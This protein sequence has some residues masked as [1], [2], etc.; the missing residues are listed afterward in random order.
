MRPFQVSESAKRIDHP[1]PVPASL[2]RF[3]LESEGN[4]P[5]YLTRLWL[6]EGVPYIFQAQ[7]MLYEQMR[8]WFGG[9]L[10][11]D[12]KEIIAIGSA[13][14]GYSLAPGEGYGREF[15]EQVSDLDLSVVSSE[16]LRKLHR[17][18]ECWERDYRAGRVEPKNHGERHYWPRNLEHIPRTLERGFIDPHLI[19]SRTEYPDVVRVLNSC[20]LLK[21]RLEVTPD[22]PRVAKVSVRVYTDWPRLVDQVALN[23]GYLRKWFL[24]STREQIQEYLDEASPTREASG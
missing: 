13:R 19:P 1:Y 12:P 14:L 15:E 3:L 24:E 23:V 7:P 20:W 11:V 2:R 22:A 10:E 8:E 5:K 6:T 17:A 21:K 18:F 16:L 9:L 4:E